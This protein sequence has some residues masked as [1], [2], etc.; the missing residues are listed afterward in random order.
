M[1]V[2]GNIKTDVATLNSEIAT[3]QQQQQNGQPLDLTALSAVAA[4]LG[5]SVS[6][7]LSA[8]QAVDAETPEVPPAA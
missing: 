1:V 2:I 5:Q 6:D 7:N 4:S 8:A 3:L